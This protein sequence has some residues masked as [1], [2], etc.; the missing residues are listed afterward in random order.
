[1][2]TDFH[3]HILPGMDDGSADVTMSLEMLRISAQQGVK[4]VVATPHFYP[5]RNNPEK[6]YEDRQR[7]WEQLGQL[8][9]DLPRVVLGAEVTYFEGMSRSAPLEAM[10]LGSSDLLLVEMPMSP[11]TDYMIDEVVSI[12]GS[13]GLQ[14]VL[15]HVDR[16]LHRSQLPRYLDYL[17]SAEVLIQ[18]NA[19]SFLEFSKRGK[20]LKLA[21]T[22][23]LDFLRSDT[24]NLTT[25]A[26]NM[27]DA[28]QVIAKKLG[29]EALQDITARSAELLGL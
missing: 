26:P 24:H 6:F 13:L 22:G 14:P 12:P 16:Y 10:R 27:A 8:P 20:M 3:S 25:R 9:D 1:M 29:E 21:K 2:L 4:T 7:A 17:L 5:T 19:E 15:A 11:W 23:L 18:A 28:A